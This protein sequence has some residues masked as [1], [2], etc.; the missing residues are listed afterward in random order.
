MVDSLN[1][2]EALSLSTAPKMTIKSIGEKV[3]NLDREVKYLLNKARFAQPLKKK[4]E[5]KEKE[6]KADAT[7]QSTPE[8]CEYKISVIYSFF[9]ISLI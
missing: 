7:T 6:P 8:Q 1:E 4:A 3:A 9:G 2:Q 5:K